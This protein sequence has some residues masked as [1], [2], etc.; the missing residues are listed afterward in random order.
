MTIVELA[1]VIGAGVEAVAKAVAYLKQFGYLNDN[2]TAD[3]LIRAIKKFQEFFQLSETGNLTE[4]TVR[5]MDTQR[6]GCPD[7]I[8]EAATRWG[9]GKN[10]ITVS[11][12]NF[13]NGLSQERQEQLLI[14]A[15]ESI[16]AVCNITFVYNG[17]GKASD[18]NIKS[19]SRGN[20][21]G[22]SGGTLAYAYLSTG[23]PVDL[24]MDLAE[25]WIDS[26]NQ[27]GILLR[28]VLCHELIHN[29]GLSHSSKKG[30]LMAPFYNVAIVSP[31]QNDDIP[32]LQGIYGAPQ[33][34]P[35]PNPV[36]NPTPTPTNKTTIE[37][38]GSVES[39]VIPGYRVTR[40]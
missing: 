13:V 21:L 26:P 31:Q 30:A 20:G 27:R 17:R 2:Y 29:L 34:K 36:P 38:V 15:L 1:R 7:L 5:A 18:I 10:R 24:V 28:N 9:F 39:I 32:R 40:I 37:I 14:E 12:H 6:C 35:N 16:E 3:D 25:T 33:P 11:Y 19:A 8:A 22:G 23:Q 4:Q